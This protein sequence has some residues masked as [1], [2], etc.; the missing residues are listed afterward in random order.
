MPAGT[1]TGLRGARCNRGRRRRETPA[2]FGACSAKP[3]PKPH[4][5]MRES[6]GQNRSGTPTGERALR[7]VRA[8]P[9]GEAGRPASVGVLLPFSFFRSFFFVARMSEATSG[10]GSEGREIVP[11]Y[12]FAHPG[13]SAPFLILMIRPFHAGVI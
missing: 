1:M 11:G 6:L 5:G 2:R 8:S 4:Q 10:M 12:R 9:Q 13:Y 3:G 7:R